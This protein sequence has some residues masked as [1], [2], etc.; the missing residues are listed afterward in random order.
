MYHDTLIRIK[1]ALMRKR[2]KVKV[3]YSTFDMNVL[4]E[5]V[6]TGYIESAERKGRGVKRIID[7]KLKYTEDG[8]PAINGIKFLS[9]PS[10]RLYSGYRDLKQSHQGYGHF[11]MS[12]PEGV[13]AGSQAKHKKVGGQVLFEI[14]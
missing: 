4:N 8:S 10:R 9:K 12:T 1:N 3:P 7:I 13:M 2:S 6:R 5:L 14:W 11:I